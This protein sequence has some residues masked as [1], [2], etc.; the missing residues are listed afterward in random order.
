MIIKAQ[1]SYTGPVNANE[2][3]NIIS[4]WIRNSPNLTING[5][6]LVI[7]PTCPVEVDLLTSDSCFDET[8]TVKQKTDIP[9]PRLHIIEIS[10]S[11][12]AFITFVGG[13]LIVACACCYHKRSYQSK[14][15]KLVLIIM[16]M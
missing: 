14:V 8:V 7:D 1:I 15:P 13:V 12:A 10:S 5:T 2:L 4:S 11:V 9:V 16:M 6:I 3:V